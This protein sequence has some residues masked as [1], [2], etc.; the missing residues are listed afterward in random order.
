RRV[1]SMMAQA[2]ISTG[3]FDDNGGPGGFRRNI[4][5]AEKQT[6]LEAADR[7]SKTEDVKD[8]LLAEAEAEYEDRPGDAP[9]ITKLGRALMDRGKSDDVKRA[10]MVY[11]KAHKELGEFRFRQAS[12]DAMIVLMRRK[13]RALRAKLEKAPESDELKAE[14]AATEN[15]LLET[16]IKELRLRVENYP[17]DL[18]LKFELGKRMFLSK[19]WEAAIEQFQLAQ[20]DAKNRRAVLN[21]MAQCFLRLGGWEDAAVSTFRQALEGIVDTGSELSLELNYGLMCA[22]LDKASVS[23]DLAAAEEADRLA[24]QIAMKKFNY[25]DVKDRREQ[26]KTL[27]AD[28]RG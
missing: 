2:A 23:R 26:I 28:I 21:M 17:T 25:R 8:R 1:K 7:I 5:D 24:S 11:N 16:E 10:I 15:S 9:T 3:G 27:L 19:E 22:L 4:R 12:G 13:L 14:L 18:G 6:Q 20:E